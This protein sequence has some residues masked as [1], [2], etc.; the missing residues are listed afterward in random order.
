M[1]KKRIKELENFASKNRI[2]FKDDSLLDVA[3]THPTYVFENK[4]RSFESNQRLEFL[5]D[6]VLGMV[7]AQYLYET[8]EQEPEGTLTKMRAAVVCEATLAR[9][10]RKLKVGQFLSLGKGEELT[11]GRD[12]NSSLADALEALIGALYLDQGIEKV[13]EFLRDNLL[14]ELDKY[15]LGNYG[16]YKTMVQELAQKVFGE[17]V[18]Y[19]IISESG[20]DHHKQFQAGISL[21]SELLAVGT[22][23]SKKEA[24]QA[25]AKKAFYQLKEENNK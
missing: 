7:V 16:D 1:E 17:N 23:N 8:F 10:A 13:K 6:A 12:R 11:G 24:E 19:H 21:K 22:G 5:G 25:A 2:I 4:G 3:F 18:F 20:P 15:E 14:N 9:I